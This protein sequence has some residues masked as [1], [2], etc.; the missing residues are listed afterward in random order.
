VRL[1]DVLSRRTRIAFEVPD[2][3]LRAAAQVAALMAAEL[4]W[5]DERTNTEI[6]QYRRAVAADLAAQNEPDDKLAF[7]ARR[8]ADDPVPFYGPSTGRGW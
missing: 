7:E 3:G 6:A 4:G 8:Q 1:D 5:D 2:R